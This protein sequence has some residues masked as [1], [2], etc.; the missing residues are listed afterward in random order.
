MNQRADQ[1][2]SSLQVLEDKITEYNEKFSQ[3]IA[4]DIKTLESRMVDFIKRQGGH[5]AGDHGLT[6]DQLRDDLYGKIEV[7]IVLVSRNRETLCNKNS[8]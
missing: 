4:T 8:M 1:Q 2:Y 7:S 3:D 6:F 5:I